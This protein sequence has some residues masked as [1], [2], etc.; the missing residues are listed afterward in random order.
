VAS[1]E[2]PLSMDGTRH[3]AG[4]RC[5]HEDSQCK[6]PHQIFG[7]H[8]RDLHF[9]EN[10]SIDIGRSQRLRKEGN[11]RINK[12]LAMRLCLAKIIEK[13]HIS[14]YFES[15]ETHLHIAENTSILIT[16]TPG[17]QNKFIDCHNAKV[18]IA[19]LPII[20][21]NTWWNSTLE[22][23][24]QAYRLR[25]FTCEWLQNPKYTD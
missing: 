19:V 3:T 16:L 17:H 1:I 11:A 22:L 10:D 18:P 15:L 13:V 25:Q 14:R 21:V 4:F 2:E 12:V 6:R 24:G 20:D 7:S 5:I 8:E 9:G 23:L